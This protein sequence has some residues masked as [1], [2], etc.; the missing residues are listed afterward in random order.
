MKVIPFDRTFPLIRVGARV[1]GPAGHADLKM[2]VDTGASITL[3]TPEMLARLGYTDEHRI[4]RTTITTPLGKEP[5]H[6]LRVEAFRSLG[7]TFTD[8]PIHAHALA[9]TAGIDGLLGL[10]FLGAFNYEI[11]SKQGLIRIELA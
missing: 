1:H 9:D 8:F 5:G 10:D 6:L 3:V 7:H 11:R 4:A 2:V